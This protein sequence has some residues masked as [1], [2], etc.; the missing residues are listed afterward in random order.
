MLKRSCFVVVTIATYVLVSSVTIRTQSVGQGDRSFIAQQLLRSAFPELMNEKTEVVLTIESPANVLWS[1][2]PTVNVNFREA[3]T[4]LLPEVRSER[5]LWTRLLTAIITVDDDQGLIRSGSFVGRF[6]DSKEFDEIAE[7]FRAHADWTL[8]QLN[9]ALIDK[10]ALF[11]PDRKNEFLAE[12]NVER[13]SAALGSI[14][15]VNI[16]FKWRDTDAP[17]RPQSV[18]EPH[19]LVSFQTSGFGN[20]RVCYSLSFEPF[21]GKLYHLYGTLCR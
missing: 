14:D 8:P 11:P 10:H 16:E 19:W 6:V 12:L 17:K 13:F 2:A 4:E 3:G 15:A 5:E 20:E 21:H 7:Q 9:A 1:R 18:E